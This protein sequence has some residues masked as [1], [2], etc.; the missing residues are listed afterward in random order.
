[1]TVKELI[2]T[3]RAYNDDDIVIM[4][5]DSEGNGYSPL[6]EAWA[7]AYRAEKTWCGDV[8][9]RALTSSLA[10]EGYDEDDVLSDGK[11]ACILSP[12]N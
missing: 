8:G 2:E 11:P 7:G 6:Y 3:L 4:A 1:M 12:M 5:R 9:L 10:E